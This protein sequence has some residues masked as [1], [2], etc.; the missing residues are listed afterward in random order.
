MHQILQSVT[1]S[2]NFEI[3]SIMSGRGRRGQSRTSAPEAPPERHVEHTPRSENASMNQPPAEP[4]RAADPGGGTLTMDQVIQI[5][6]AATRHVREPPEEQRGMI[7]RALKLGAKTYDG[8]GDPEAA[9]L[10]LDRVR[11]IYAVMGCS[12]EQKVLFSGFLMAA[13]AKDWWEAIKRRHLTG[14]TCNQFR[15]AFTD[16]F[17][18]RSYQDA[19]IEEFFRLEQQSLTVTEYEQ[20]FS[21][22]VK[23]VPM[24]QENEEHKCKR[25]MAGLN[26]RI[27]IHLA[28]ASQNNFG[29][30]VE[31]T[32]RVERTVSVL[33]QGRPDSKRGAPSTSQPGTSQYS[34][35][36]GKK[37]TSGR[38]SR[39]G[40][41]SS[42]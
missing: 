31:A 6:T 38:G 20:R 7:E 42:Q 9:Y 32:L 13:R 36:K 28:W 26:D 16:R 39:R 33:T 1:E 14:V 17:Y 34:R 30:L 5:V 37:W 22:L 23:L 29:E 41:A 11:E 18:P 27:K 4:L 8:T 2:F 3:H 15:Q 35:K 25:F 10:W 12:D 19:K 24:I 40:A 21:E